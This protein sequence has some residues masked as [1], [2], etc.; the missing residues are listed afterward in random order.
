MIDWTSWLGTAVAAGIVLAGVVVI[1][2]V[3]SLVIAATTRRVP[4]VRAFFQRIRARLGAVMLIAGLWVVCAASAPGDQPWWPVLERGF[5]I[6]LILGCGWLISAVGTFGLTRAINRLDDEAPTAEV[7]RMRTQLTL[8]RRLVAVLIAVIAFG[9]VLFTFP[10]VQ[11]IGAGVLASAGVIS[12]VAGLAAQS[13]LGNL[14]AGIQIAFSDSVRV[15]DVVVVEGEWGRIGEITLTYVVV[16]IWDERRLV[17]PCTYFTTQPFE[18]WTRHSD[19]VLGTVYMDLDWRVPIADVR[20]KFDEIIEG[21]EDWDR[22]ASSVLVTGSQG[23]LVTLRFLVSAA[24]SG[25]QWRLRCLV[26]EEMIGW[27]QREHPEALPTT[28]V[29]MEGADSAG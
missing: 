10:E 16:Y 7:R 23:G 1:L 4:S 22:R 18:T 24:D 26:R 13:T 6:V 14:L 3:L 11:A 2:V 8:V 28:R 20:T 25:A 19:K 9:A 12:I 29:R 21:T 27:L 5:L 15:G 17:L